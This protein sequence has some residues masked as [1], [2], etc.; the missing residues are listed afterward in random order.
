VAQGIFDTFD[1]E[2]VGDMI[3]GLAART[4]SKILDVFD[5]PDESARD[6]AIDV[7]TIRFRL[8]GLA[9]DRILGLPDGSVTVLTRAQVKTLLAAMPRTY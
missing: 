4:N 8:H 1:P 2:G 3:Q 5:A 6:H 7:L 9:I